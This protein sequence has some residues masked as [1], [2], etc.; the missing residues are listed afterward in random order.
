LGDSALAR[1][2]NEEPRSRDICEV[3]ECRIYEKVAQQGE[4]SADSAARDKSYAAYT[5]P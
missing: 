5:I 2:R 1:V 4:R 3:A